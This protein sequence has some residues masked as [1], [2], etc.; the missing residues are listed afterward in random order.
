MKLVISVFSDSIHLCGRQTVIGALQCDLQRASWRLN[1]PVTILLF[2][3]L[4]YARKSEHIKA[5]H[6][7][8]FERVI[9][10]WPVDPSQ[11]AS[12]AET[13]PFHDVVMIWRGR[14]DANLFVTGNLT[15]VR[16]MM[17]TRHCHLLSSI[18]FSQWGS[19]IYLSSASML[20]EDFRSWVPFCGFLV[21]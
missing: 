11:R 20:C 16:L 15:V 19:W 18:R 2:N 8:S 3:T 10:R 9:H 1:S 14:Y 7:L 12:N 6:Y 13:F 21:G 5:E 4:V 17:T